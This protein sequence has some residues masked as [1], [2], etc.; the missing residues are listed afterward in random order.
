M[1]YKLNEKPELK[2]LPG[3]CD[4]SNETSENNIE[5]DIEGASGLKAQI[6][7]YKKVMIEDFGISENVFF[8]TIPVNIGH[9][10]SFISRNW[11]DLAGTRIYFA[12]K[13]NDPSVDDYELLFV[14]CKAIKDADGKVLY[15]EDK[16]NTDKGVSSHI[17]SVECR[18]PPDCTQGALLL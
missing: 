5:L 3:E 17:I 13:T 9:I 16:L 12:K 2:A 1:I 14:P 18:K 6:A 10:L 4:V 11:E 15:Y 7:N 8:D